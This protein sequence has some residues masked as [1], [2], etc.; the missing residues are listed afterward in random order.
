MSEADTTLAG[1]NR[2]YRNELVFSSSEPA[3]QSKPK[4]HNVIARSSDR[5]GSIDEEIGE[6]LGYEDCISDNESH[7]NIQTME[8]ESTST[9]SRSLYRD[10]PTIVSLPVTCKLTAPLRSI[11]HCYFSLLEMEHLP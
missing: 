6:E 7:D 11:I 4:M 2:S 10:I 1:L 9:M 5:P 3:P 8:I